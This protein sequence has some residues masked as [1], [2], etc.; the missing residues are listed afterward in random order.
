MMF[1]DFGSDERRAVEG[2][3][4]L[5]ELNPRDPEIDDETFAWDMADWALLQG[6]TVR[7][8]A[9]VQSARMMI[10]AQQE[11]KDFMVISEIGI[12]ALQEY[13]RMWGGGEI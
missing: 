4:A 12:A 11:G 1:E 9:M 13:N 2:I 3:A 6:P 5:L 7:W 8:D 10:A